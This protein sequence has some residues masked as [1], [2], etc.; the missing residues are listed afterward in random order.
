MLST[1]GP[2]CP[3]CGASIEPGTHLYSEIANSSWHRLCWKHTTST[4]M[5]LTIV[6]F[7]H[8]L[9]KHVDAKHRCTAIICQMLLKKRKDLYYICCTEEEKGPLLYLLYWRR[10]R[11][12]TTFVVLKKRKDLYYICCTSKRK[13]L[14]YICCTSNISDHEL[15][16]EIWDILIEWLNDWF[17]VALHNESHRISDTWLPVIAINDIKVYK[18]Y[19]IDD[20]YLLSV[21]QHVYYIKMCQIIYDFVLLFYR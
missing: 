5:H 2:S 7:N 4:E 3:T 8:E 18:K 19:Q 11:T 16:S 15:C 6:W 10:E 20:V 21:M 1:A 14:Y 12:F 17:E 13:D 9:F